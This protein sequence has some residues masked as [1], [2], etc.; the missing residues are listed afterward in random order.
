VGEPERA[1]AADRWCEYVTVALGNDGG[2][3][4]TA[5]TITFRTHVIDALDIDWAT[6]ETKGALPVP[7]EAG[8]RR[9]QTWHVCLESW[10]VPLGMRVET[11]DVE[12]DWE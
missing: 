9:R 10:R 7:I 8:A 2:K 4:V 5:G 1:A 3:P 11:Q 12:V 6:V